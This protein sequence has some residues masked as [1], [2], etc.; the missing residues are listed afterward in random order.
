MGSKQLQNLHSLEF[1]MFYP[2]FHTTYNAVKMGINTVNSN[3]HSECPVE[4]QRSARRYT[5]DESTIEM[6]HVGILC[7][8]NKNLNR[9]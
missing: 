3:L 4:L 7:S 5:H 1:S 9:I 2:R 6:I 8:M